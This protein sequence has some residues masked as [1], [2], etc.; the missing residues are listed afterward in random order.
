MFV[1]GGE[2]GKEDN[3]SPIEA[4]KVFGWKDREAPLPTAISW[5][6]AALAPPTNPNPYTPITIADNRNIIF[7]ISLYYYYRLLLCSRLKGTW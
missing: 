7:V 2:R 3:L 5:V 4:V 1:L 6:I